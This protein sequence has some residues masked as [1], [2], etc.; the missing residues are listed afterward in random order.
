M[1]M[2]GLVVLY[3]WRVKPGREA[4]FTEA[5]SAVTRSLLGRGSLGSR[6]HRG[7]DGLWY[8]YA[9]W[10]SADARRAAFQQP[11]DDGAN[12]AAM[13]DAVAESFPELLLHPVEDHLRAERPARTLRVARPTLDLARALAFWTEVVG[14]PL[15]GRFAGHDG[16]DGAIMG[17]PDG[18]WQLELTRH[19][20]GAPRPTPTDEDL[21]VLYV[22]TAEA[23]RIAQS[24]AAAG[25]PPVEH[26]NPYWKARGA[27]VFR[28]TD[29]CAL[30]LF[31]RD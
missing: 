29:G 31:P 14:V 7:D 16:Y 15:L 20:S 5:W 18:T 19:A 2:P 10:P 27:R 8:G 1:S 26:P 21:L 9:Q 12:L 17:P 23:E 11:S 22:G 4:Q 30:V 6:L 28:D 24:L 3:R 13:R 25:H